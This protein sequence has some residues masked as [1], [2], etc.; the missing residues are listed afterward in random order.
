MTLLYFI[1][2]HHLLNIK[3]LF[4]VTHLDENM[5]AYIAHEF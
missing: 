3:T 5:L 4:N 1:H 2:D